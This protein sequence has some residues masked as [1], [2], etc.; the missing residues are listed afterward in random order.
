MVPKQFLISDSGNS[1]SRSQTPH[2]LLIILPGQTPKGYWSDLWRYRTLLVAMARRE[3]S[4]RYK[5][6]AIGLSWALIQPLATMILFT[7]IFSEVAK[8]HPEAGTPY[9]LMVFAGLLPWQWFASSLNGAANS[10]VGNA[11]LIGKVYFP[12][13]IIPISAMIL[14]FVDFVISFVILVGLMV[15]H[16]FLPGW[17]I[18]TLPFF[19]LMGILASLGP[20]LW[21]TAMNVKYRDFRYVI[22]FLTQFGL[23][24]SPV[25]FSSTLISQDWRLL[26]S[27]NPIV[28]VID[29]FR[30]A[31]LGGQ[32]NFYMP[33][34]LLSWCVIAV[35]LWIGIR[36]FRKMEKN[37]ADL[38]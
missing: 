19:I 34:F 37:F 10:M 15:W 14:S 29:G 12:R 30:W 31:I 2:E 7:F 24:L 18:L 27:L 26:Y 21:L 38:F 11:N 32:T 9:S 6:T 33:G 36:K 20:G 25:G 16:Q 23:Y 8:L 28:G 22:P 5:Q 35:T 17:Q 13:L 4:V 3:I 1:A